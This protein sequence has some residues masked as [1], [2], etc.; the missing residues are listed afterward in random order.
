MST[1]APTLDAAAKPKQ[2]SGEK[3]E[4]KLKGN[5]ICLPAPT[6]FWS[7]YC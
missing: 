2:A 7:W 6:R 1:V 3:F 4:F 5:T